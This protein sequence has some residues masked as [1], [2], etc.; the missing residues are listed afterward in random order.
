M[1][2]S[3]TTVSKCSGRVR[4]RRVLRGRGGAGVEIRGAVRG[5]VPLTLW[6]NDFLS[7]VTPALAWWATFVDIYVG[8]LLVAYMPLAACL[9]GVVLERREPQS[10]IA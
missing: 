4:R 6:F 2:R 1:R 10:T 3:A 8:F 5:A 9:S 7:R